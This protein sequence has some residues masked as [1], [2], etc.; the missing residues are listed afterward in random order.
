MMRPL[1][2]PATPVTRVKAILLI[3]TNRLGGCKTLKGKQASLALPWEAGGMA[4]LPAEWRTLVCLTTHT[5]LCRTILFRGGTRSGA[6]LEQIATRPGSAGSFWSNTPFIAP[7]PFWF[8]LLQC[9]P[10]ARDIRVQV[11]NCKSSGWI[12]AQQ[13]WLRGLYLIWYEMKGTMVSFRTARKD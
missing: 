10:M 13:I 2:Q 8:S 6:A 3:K 12:W 4:G 9:G 7:M 11:G 1:S 5:G